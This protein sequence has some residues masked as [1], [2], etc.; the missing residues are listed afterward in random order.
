M[1]GADYQILG[2]LACSMLLG[3]FRGFVRVS[4]A[5]LAWLGGLWLAWR[6]AFLFEPLFSGALDERAAT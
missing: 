5:L 1:N 2:V 6:Y 4:V 3:L